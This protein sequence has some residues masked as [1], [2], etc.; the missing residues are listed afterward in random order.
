MC[1]PELPLNNARLNVHLT[2][3]LSDSICHLAI[4]ERSEAQARMRVRTG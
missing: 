4:E 2:F 3:L 1:K